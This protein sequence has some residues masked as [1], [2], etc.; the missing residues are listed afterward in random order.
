MSSTYTSGVEEPTKGP[1]YTSGAKGPIEGISSALAELYRRRWLAVYFAQRELSRSY[2]SSYLGMLWALLG[3]LLQIVLL[4]IVFSE[5]I[6]IRFR[7]VTGDSTLNFGLFLYCGLIPFLAFSET[8]NK[9][10]NSV[11]SNAALVQKVVFPLEILPLTRAITVLINMVFG[12][13]VLIL[14]VVLLEGRLRWTILLIPL[15]VALQLVFT[16]GLSYLFA[17]IGTYLPDTRETLRSFVRALFFITPI[18]WPAGRV[19]ENLSFLVDYNPLAFLVGAYR[20]LV[21]EETFPDM[22]GALY[23]SVF[24]IVLLVVGFVLFVRVKQKFADLI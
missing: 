11:R 9:A 12:L 13:G 19:P 1:I 18:I 16:L 3:P 14:V 23:F 10:S 7:E 2:R 4:T 22:S 8:L 15:L 6:G 5:I 20:S 17:V 24:S 21:L